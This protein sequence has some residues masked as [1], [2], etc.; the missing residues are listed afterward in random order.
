M[1]RIFT[2]TPLMVMN[3]HS[4]NKIRRRIANG[5]LNSSKR[6]PDEGK[7]RSL[8]ILG[9]EN[10]DKHTGKVHILRSRHSSSG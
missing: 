1:N 8:Y 4:Q 9:Y 7:I 6:I 2:D 5:Q 3:T 10:E